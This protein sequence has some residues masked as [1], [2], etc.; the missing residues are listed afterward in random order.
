MKTIEL[1]NQQDWIII[2]DD[3]HEKIQYVFTDEIYSKLES[4]IIEAD[5]DLDYP[6]LEGPRLNAPNLRLLGFRGE[7]CKKCIQRLNE[8]GFSAPVVETIGFESIG[9]TQIPEFIFNFKTI[10]DIHFRKEKLRVLPSGLFDLINLQTLRFQYGSQI[11][12]IP[13]AIK[14]LVNLEYFDFWG[15]TLDYLSPELFLLPKVKYINFTDSF[16]KPTKEVEDAMY[17]FNAKNTNDFHCWQP[18]KAV[19]PIWM[20]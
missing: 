18:F 7:G 9:I 8:N 16:Y 14:N 6:L 15:A 1:K 11:P 2:L 3:E 19:K 10:K 12:V 4:I 5:F 17:E 20:K 13:D